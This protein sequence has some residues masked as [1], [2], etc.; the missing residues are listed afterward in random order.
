MSRATWTVYW[1]RTVCAWVTVPVKSLRK[2]TKIGTISNAGP[3]IVCR[4]RVSDL[5]VACPEPGRVSAAASAPNTEPSASRK[6]YPKTSL[7]T[8]KPPVSPRVRRATSRRL[9]IVSPLLQRDQYRDEG[10]P[11]H[12]SHGLAEDGTECAVTVSCRVPGSVRC[13]QEVAYRNERRVRLDFAHHPAEQGDRHSV[14]LGVALVV[15]PDRWTQ[16]TRTGDDAGH[17]S[18]VG[19]GACPQ[20]S[21][22]ADDHHGSALDQLRVVR[23]EVLGAVGTL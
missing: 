7:V 2:P 8:E 11:C 18:V 13:G 14:A 16:V 17:P 6:M 3:R 4:C 15:Q 23:L 1:A 21:R 22:G 10:T 12:G 19:T 5:V 20:V 9:S